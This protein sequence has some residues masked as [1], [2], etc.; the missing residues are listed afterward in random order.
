MTSK[1][2]HPKDV[3]WFKTRFTQALEVKFWHAVSPR[4]TIRCLFT[5]LYLKQL[6][7][8]NAISL[9]YTQQENAFIYFIFFNL[10]ECY[11][12]GKRH[13][14]FSN[15]RKVKKQTLKRRIRLKWKLYTLISISYLRFYF[16][17]SE[18]IA[19]SMLSYYS[20]KGIKKNSFNISLGFLKQTFF[21]N[22]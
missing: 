19:T 22:T 4:L 21:G 1:E 9:I 15:A 7:A 11:S 20:S 18:I 12:S 14:L 17:D 6:I 2:S 8:F 10:S 16:R 5:C 13:F 3:S